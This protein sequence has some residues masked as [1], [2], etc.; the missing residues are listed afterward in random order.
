MKLNLPELLKVKSNFVSKQIT[1]KS[2]IREYNNPKKI[3]TISTVE[4]KKSN[5]KY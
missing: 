2:N 1:K 5:L 4:I 3:K